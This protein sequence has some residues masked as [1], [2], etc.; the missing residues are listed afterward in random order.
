M[1]LCV[2][3]KLGFKELARPMERVWI[4]SGTFQAKGHHS[5]DSESKLLLK[6]TESRMS[7][8]RV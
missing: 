6:L 7:A 2:N 4:W 8:W 3:D 1:H 5:E